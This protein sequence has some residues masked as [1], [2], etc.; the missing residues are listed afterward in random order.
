MARTA[1]EVAQTLEVIAGDDPR[2]PQWVRGPI[3]TEPYTQTLTT[4]IQGLRIGM[5]KEGLEGRAVE[6]EVVDAFQKGIAQ[7]GTLGVA[8]SEISSADVQKRLGHLD[9]HRQPFDPRAGRV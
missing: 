5:V 1:Q 6:P 8:C 9:G 7:L 3:Q 4:D 2:D